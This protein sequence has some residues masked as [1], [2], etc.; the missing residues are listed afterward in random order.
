M[1]NGAVLDACRSFII[2]HSAFIILPGGVMGTWMRAALGAALA[3]SAVWTLL[4][5]APRARRRAERAWWT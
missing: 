2:Q 5:V 4:E 1:M 3:A